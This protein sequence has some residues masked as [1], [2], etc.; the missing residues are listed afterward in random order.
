MHSF[1]SHSLNTSNGP[2]TTLGTKS[3]SVHKVIILCQE[4]FCM[5]SNISIIYNLNTEIILTWNSLF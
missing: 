4:T 2:E 5:C 3:L 1:I